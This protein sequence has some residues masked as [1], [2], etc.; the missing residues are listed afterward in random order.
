MDAMVEFQTNTFMNTH[1]MPRLFEQSKE[2]T[3]LL[4]EIPYELQALCNHFNV[5]NGTLYPFKD[6]EWGVVQST[7]LE[8]RNGDRRRLY[9]TAIK[10]QLKIGDRIKKKLVRYCR[11]RLEDHYPGVLTVKPHK[12]NQAYLNEIDR[13]YGLKL[14]PDWVTVRISH[15]DVGQSFFKV[16]AD[17]NHPMWVGELYFLIQEQSEG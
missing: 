17:D 6:F 10:L 1:E 2:E 11:L 5:V 14:S 8:V 15:N 16:S 9:P 13:V 12:T 7:T 4:A 3:S